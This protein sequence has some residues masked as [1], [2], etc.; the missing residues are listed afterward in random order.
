MKSVLVTESNMTTERAVRRATVV[1]RKL[2]SSSQSAARERLS[3]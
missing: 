2:V 1:T 3:P